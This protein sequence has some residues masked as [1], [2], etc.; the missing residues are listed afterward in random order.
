[1]MVCSWLRLYA[2]L[3][4]FSICF[5]VPL[6][7]PFMDH[8][9]TLWPWPLYIVLVRWN[10]VVLKTKHV[11][12]ISLRH[13]L[14]FFS[15]ILCVSG[16]PVIIHECSTCVTGVREECSGVLPAQTLHH[17]L[18]LHLISSY[19]PNYR[20]LRLYFKANCRG[21]KLSVL[22]YRFCGNLRNQKNE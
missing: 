6:A 9:L 17:D 1:M 14:C 3:Y 21:L 16:N 22:Q 10:I 15:G 19:T 11:F 18:T 2:F 12:P 20:W 7:F 13:I 8:L 5:C 4:S